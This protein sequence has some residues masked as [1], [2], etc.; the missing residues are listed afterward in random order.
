MINIW[1]VTD[2]GLVRRENQDAY[3]VQDTGTCGFTVCVVCD[4]MGGPGGG[5]LASELAV[6]TFMSVCLD[7]L[8]P[9]MDLEGA[10]QVA[11]SAVAAANAA[12][13]ER[14]CEGSMRG[15]GTTL[16][17]ALV[18]D[19]RAL[20]NNVGDSR[21]YLIRSGGDIARITKD[22]SLV[23]RLVDRGDITAG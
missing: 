17:S 5:K 11:E 1:G 19:G 7:K 18:R 20:L 16:V 22:H 15:M 4:G 9:E 14:S 3:A 21:A 13:Y 23:E 6:E 12:V 10:K 2:I 8:S